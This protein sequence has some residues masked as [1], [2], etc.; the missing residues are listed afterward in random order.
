VT[1][2]SNR[3]FL[4]SG[5]RFATELDE[6]LMAMPARYLIL[7]NIGAKSPSE[8]EW[9]W[10]ALAGSLAGAC[11]EG[12]LLDWA[13]RAILCHKVDIDMHSHEALQHS[14]VTYAH[15]VLADV[16]AHL[17][18]QAAGAPTF[19]GCG[20]NKDLVSW[21]TDESDFDKYWAIIGSLLPQLNEALVAATSRAAGQPSITP[22][23]ASNSP[24]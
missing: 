4:A 19:Q 10:N 12:T 3:A 1:N 23:A 14:F 15:E 16:E 8:A 20:K 9:K 18:G 5:D 7:G 13:T 11:G 6:R 22:Q 2:A 24:Q 17:A 21:D